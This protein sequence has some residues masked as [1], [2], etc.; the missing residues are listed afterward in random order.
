MT[1]RA[2]PMEYSV[3]AMT[4]AGGEAHKVSKMSTIAFDGTPQTGDALP[5]LGKACDLQGTIRAVAKG[6]ITR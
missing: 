6:A 3:T 2:K 4:R 5:G 1:E